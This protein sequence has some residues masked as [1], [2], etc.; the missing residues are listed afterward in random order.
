MY[1]FLLIF[2]SVVQLLTSDSGLQHC[3]V[4]LHGVYSETS[5]PIGILEVSLYTIAR[6][7]GVYVLLTILGWAFQAYTCAWFGLVSDSVDQLSFSV[8]IHVVVC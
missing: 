5:L 8:L 6:A 4:E 3:F 2:W 1:V 7:V